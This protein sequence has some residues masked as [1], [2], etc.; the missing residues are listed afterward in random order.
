MIGRWRYD[1]RARR[2]ASSRGSTEV[3]DVTAASNDWS[4][5]RHRR[6]VA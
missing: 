6:A 3:T 1:I 2:A 5:Q 4:L